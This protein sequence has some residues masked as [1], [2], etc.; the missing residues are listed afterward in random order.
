MWSEAMRVCR[1][2]LPSQEAALRRELTQKSTGIDGNT[3]LDEARRWLEAGEIRTA[4]D[5]L[6]L[7]SHAS[8]Q[9]LIQAADIL[10]NQADPDI[11]MQVGNELGAKLVNHNEHALAAQVYLQSDKLKDAI[12]ALASIGD[13]VRARRIV[14]ELAPELE[15][16]LEDRYR[17]NVT[18][19]NHTERII[20]M[21]S[22]VSLESLARKGQWIQVF[23][24]ASSQN[25]ELLHKYVAQRAAQLLKSGTPEQALHLYSQY[26]T[27]P[28]SQYHNLYYR[29][30]E[31]ILNSYDGTAETRYNRL[32]HLRNFLHG[33][34]K[35]IEGSAS[36]EEKFGRLLQAAHYSAIKNACQSFPTLAQLTVKTSISL[37]RFSDILLADRCYYDAGVESRNAGNHSEGFVFL[38]HFLDLEECIEEGDGSILDVDDLR[39]TDFPLEVPLPN[40]LSLTREEREEVREWVLA[41]SMDQ[42]VEQGLPVDQRGVYTGSL[43]CP[44][45]GSAPLQACALTGYPIRG[46]I[47]RF[48]GSSRVVDRDD[49]N[50]LLNTARQAP[51]DS[52]L[53]DVLVF[54]QEWCGTLPSYTF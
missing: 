31:V 47:V 40:N 46:S 12:N 25:P 17:D 8:R 45:N 7:D 29:L 54:V 13:W 52:A 4:L 53:N 20:E 30:S 23:E 14:R 32:S 11:A 44:A 15:T 24:Q 50:K 28:I 51:Q 18:R 42:R 21:E 5:I 36:S 19:E 1:E 37:L 27:P 41:V 48:E 49:W 26:G 34:T 3:S 35:Q 10:L 39:I 6:I 16:Y 2:Y 43:T 22:D 38:N 33:L 9:S